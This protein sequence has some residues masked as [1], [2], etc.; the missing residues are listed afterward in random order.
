MRGA[1]LRYIKGKIAAPVWRL[2]IVDVAGVS[3]AR[4]E[5]AG[6]LTGAPRRI[7]VYV[8]ADRVVDRCGARLLHHLAMT[9]RRGGGDLAVVAPSASLRTA[10]GALG[11]DGELPMLDSVERA[12]RWARTRS[13]R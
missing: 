3:R 2:H 5:L 8:G 13:A 7:L 10:V 11:L 6:F 12:T 1:A 9:V 4:V